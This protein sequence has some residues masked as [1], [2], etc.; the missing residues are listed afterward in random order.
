MSGRAP[1]DGLMTIHDAQS[2]RVS[3]T[4]WKQLRAL[5][6]KYTKCGSEKKGEKDQGTSE[7]IKTMARVL[8]VNDKSR[9]WCTA[10]VLITRSS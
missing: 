5:Q 8:F 7:R 6:I 3:K 1:P 10:K 2:R 4:F 9:D